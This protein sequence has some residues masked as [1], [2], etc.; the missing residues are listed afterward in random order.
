MLDLTAPSQAIELN[1]LL[2]FVNART[3]DMGRDELV[4]PFH[5]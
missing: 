5:L 4:A 3:S 1:D 2:K